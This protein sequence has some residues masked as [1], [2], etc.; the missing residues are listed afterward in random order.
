MDFVERQ[1]YGDVF[2]QAT[3]FLDNVMVDSITLMALVRMLIEKGVLTKEEFDETVKEYLSP[4]P[5]A[6]RKQD[7][8]R[9]SN[10]MRRFVMKESNQVQEPSKVAHLEDIDR[11][12]RALQNFSDLEFPQLGGNPT[13][14]LMMDNEKQALLNRSL[15]AL[16]QAWLTL[17]LAANLSGPPKSDLAKVSP[18][19]KRLYECYLGQFPSRGVHP[20][21]DALLDQT[22]LALAYAVGGLSKAVPSVA[23]DESLRKLL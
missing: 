19:I 15:T 8:M 3:V 11:L 5:W 7:D 18:L 14:Y 6:E 20:E 12:I 21:V 23:V 9:A 2:K 13:M 17:S 4:T 10:H 22:R 1:M 16:D